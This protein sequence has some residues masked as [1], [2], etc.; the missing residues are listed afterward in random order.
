MDPTFIHIREWNEAF[1]TRLNAAIVDAL[2]TGQI[3]RH[4]RTGYIG[5]TMSDAF[6]ICVVETEKGSFTGYAFCGYKEQFSRKVGRAI[7]QGRAL[8]LA[9]AA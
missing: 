1:L 6:T 9:E 7:A 2:S 8:A 5:A 3:R 4:A